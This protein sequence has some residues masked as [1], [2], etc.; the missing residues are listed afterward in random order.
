MHHIYVLLNSNHWLILCKIAHCIGIAMKTVHTSLTENI[1]GDANEWS[2]QMEIALWQ[3]NQLQMLQVANC[4]IKSG[5]VTIPQPKPLTVPTYPQQTIF[6][7]LPKSES[8]CER[9]PPW[10]PNCCQ[11]RL[12]AP[13][14]TF[15]N[16]STKEPPS[17]FLL[18]CQQSREGSI[19]S[20]LFEWNS[21]FYMK[22][23]YF[24][25]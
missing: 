5:I 18:M 10:D 13:L 7:L 15:W 25:T 22:L 12:Q 19:S 17:H 6:Y 24:L 4:L 16:L 8:L 1:Y 20:W 23:F 2:A 21:G 3:C 14:R 11:R 9:T